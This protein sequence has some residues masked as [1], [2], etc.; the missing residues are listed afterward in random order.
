M[1]LFNTNKSSPNF[2][3][4]TVQLA[5]VATASPPYRINQ[6]DA[7]TFLKTHYAQKLSSRNQ[8]V[9]RKVF[10]HPSIA[11]R[12]FAFDD[13][14]C[15]INENA[16]KRVERFTHWAVE[17]SAE[18]L[19]KAL[20]LAGV[21]IDT[22]GGIVVN[23]CT[24]YICPG[25]ST[26]LIEKIGLPRTIPAYDLVGSGCG[27]AIP[28]LQIAEKLLNSVDEQVIA[29]V[30]VEICSATFQME[31]DVSLIV[32]NALFGDGAAASILSNHHKGLSLVSSVSHFVP[33]YRESIRYIYKN[34]K[35]HNQLSSDLPQIVRK[36]V[37]E[38][39]SELLHRY[40]LHAE[41]IKHWA[42]HPGGDKIISGIQNELGLTDI[43]LKPTRNVLANYG[44][45]SSAT[46]W[47]II[48]EILDNGIAPGEWVIMVAF[49][50]G[51]STHAYLMQAK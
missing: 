8:A 16:D 41:D 42:L 32:S 33:E 19:M 27:G 30:S 34:G 17:L 45:M 28:N 11:Q 20:N 26:Y 21:S 49:G 9:M 13:P 10:R 51:F 39:V 31:D 4:R 6:S 36:P 47:F 1:T 5:S 48:R 12:Y 50:A 43:Q 14:V 37:A 22:V 38:V 23:T 3:Q 29:S 35:L 7:E 2:P 25:I 44:N 40:G 18:A 15:L 46:V 24:G